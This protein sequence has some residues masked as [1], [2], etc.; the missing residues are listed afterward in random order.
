MVKWYGSGRADVKLGSSGADTLWGQG[1]DDRLD[2][3]AGNDVLYG[4]DGNDTLTGGEGS[5]SL[6]GGAGDDRL[7]GGDDAYGATNHLYG[8]TGNDTYV[9]PV[10]EYRGED[11]AVSIIHERAGEGTDTV[12]YRGGEE[13]ILA[14]DVAVE[15]IVMTAGY[16]VGGNRLDNEIRGS[17]DD[18]S[19]DGGAGN[20][21]LFGNDGHDELFGGLGQDDLNG[22]A[23]ADELT[24]GAGADR[25]WFFRTADSTAAAPDMLWDFDAA[26][27][28]RIAFGAF[29]A[30]SALAG[31]QKFQFVG[32]LAGGAETLAAGQMGT[33]YDAALDATFLYGNTG[34]DARPEF[35]V[36]LAGHVTLTAGSF[37][38]A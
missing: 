19:I 37:L 26:G 31:P 34:G 29:D 38:W 16:Q 11:T 35:M 10:L 28:D 9:L 27:G 5:D 4:G 21:R 33:H 32:A 12:I 15:N 20:D 17:A 18:N 3:G 6:Y 1:G 8:G 30:N 23:G 13:F 7:D 2:G 14:D 22:G 24:G 25:F 36:Q